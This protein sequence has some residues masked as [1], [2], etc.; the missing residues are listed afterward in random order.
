MFFSLTLRLRHGCAW[1]LDVSFRQQHSPASSVFSLLTFPLDKGIFELGWVV[2]IQIDRSWEGVL[3]KGTGCAVTGKVLLD[4][5]FKA[6]LGRTVN[7]PPKFRVWS[8]L[9]KPT[10]PPGPSTQHV[11][12]PGQWRLKSCWPGCGPQPRVTLAQRNIDFSTW[13][14][15]WG[16]FL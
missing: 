16:C 13:S 1:L 8:L 6:V 11:I 15:C 14:T 3:G 2:V 5:G 9:T 4:P 12:V 7:E 10:Y